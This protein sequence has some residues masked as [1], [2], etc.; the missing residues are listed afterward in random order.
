MVAWSLMRLAE[1]ANPRDRG[2]VQALRELEGDPS[3]YVGK[4]ADW[5]LQRI[6]ERGPDRGPV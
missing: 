5:A 4:G 1:R 6:L 3:T 2:P